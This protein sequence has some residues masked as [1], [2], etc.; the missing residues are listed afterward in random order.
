[1]P[2][3]N[4]VGQKSSQ[5]KTD[6]APSLKRRK[7]GPSGSQVS[8]QSSFADVLEQLTIDNGGN[9]AVYPGSEGGANCWPRPSL[10]PLDEKRDTII[11]QQIDIEEGTDHVNGEI[12]LRMFG[13]TE[14]GHSVMAN[15]T[16]FPPYFYVPVPRGFDAS[17]LGPLMDALNKAAGGHYVRK[18]EIVRKRSLWGYRGDD[19]IPFMKL[20]TSE[21]RSLPKVR[22]K[23]ECQ[24]R[25]FFPLG[26]S[27]P[28]FESNVPYVL[29]FMIDTKVV[30]MNWIEIPAGKYTL[31]SDG[32]KYDAFISHSPEG[33]WQKIAPLRIL[34]FDIECAG[35]KGIFPE[36]NVDP[37]I[38]IANMVTRQ[39][40]NQPFIRNVFTLNSCSHI[41][42]SQ[43]LSFD[44]EGEML[45][46]WR[47]FIEEVDPDLVI[48]YNV[49]NFDFPYLMDRA[50]HLKLNRFPYL[51]RLRGYKT[52]VKDT[53]FSSKAYGQRDSKD[54]VLEGRLQLDVLQFMQRE[55]KLRSYTL[56]SVCAQFLGEQKEDVHHSV[57]TEL[58]L[59]T[60]ESRRRLA[61]YCLK[62]AYLP[63]RLLDK[64]MC[65]VNYVEMARVTG[66]PF[67]YLLSRGQSIKVLSQLFRKA[68][69]EGYV[70]PSLKGEGTDEQ[71]EG[72]TVIE[73]KKG[74]Y[75]VP[76]ATLDF[77][78]LY[79]SIMMAHNLCYT[80]LLDKATIDRLNLVKDVDYIQTPNN[81]F[82]TTK[83]KRKGLLP[84]VLEDLIGARKRAKADLKKETDPFRRA[85]LDGRQ[86]ALKISAN[87][88]YG[89]TGATIGKLPCLPISSSVTAYGRQMIERTKQE[90][91]AEFC[92][93]NGHSYNAEVIYGD[94]DS[95]MV[96]FGPTEL[97]AVM[98]LGSQAA[99]FVTAK[100]VKPIKLEFEKVYFPYL[101][102]SKKRYAG[103]YWTKPEKYDKMDSKGI[104]TVRRDNCRLVQTVIETC[105]HKMLI[106]R[107]VKGAEEYTKRIISDLLQNKVDMSQLVITKAL[108]KSDYAAKQAHVELA[109]RMKQR[110]AG[111]APA[112][113]DRVAYVIVKGIKGAAAYEKSEDPLYVL[114]N[115]IPIDTKYYLENQLSKPLMRIFE[116]ILGEKANS[117]LSGG[118]TRSIA[119]ATP[120]VGGL[121]KFAVKTAICLGC[122][123]PLRPNNSVPNGAVCNNCRPRVGELYRKQVSLASE[124][125]IRFSRLW[126]QCQRCQ[127]SL[128]QDVLCS[129]KDCPIFY[130]RKK[131]QKDVED[132]NAILERFDADM[133]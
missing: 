113:G 39:G 53:H 17:D 56:N 103:L 125:Q 127:G 69:E 119:I 47:D 99:E 121:M 120:T 105:L 7:L 131:A 54:T 20:V 101:L 25:D 3:K 67:N 36:A 42:G 87:S 33:D 78:S 95:V 46:A 65:F 8:Q 24:F 89:F 14:G 43:V 72:A 102:I 106:D 94:T 129:S 90:V 80:T 130:M 45:Q 4:G 23:G 19:W 98:D 68:N 109:E 122:K 81:D 70:V 1:M 64:L 77:S 96:K 76:I 110:D 82:F 71:Y 29:R 44:D 85:V 75:D 5:A 28:T 92:I 126:T 63:Q 84:T 104:E 41:V 26:Q 118:H 30:G 132:A 52:Q 13:V 48:G 2:S 128:H 60:P 32:R 62:D 88:V 49:T 107:D 11:F 15:V 73:P 117:L 18:I 133:W 74:Y 86:L 31:V 22:D 114:E 123:T 12:I 83:A 37:V 21:A 91:E 34:S 58:Q 66:V 9:L 59:G 61:V 79:P 100:F 115:N 35:R 6:A 55:H 93:S 16:N 112:L 124:Q 116:P 111:S 51:G 97:K 108:A 27:Y 38:Q 57:I 10:K 40:E 50:K